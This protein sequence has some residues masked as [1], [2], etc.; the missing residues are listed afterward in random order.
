MNVYLVFLEEDYV[1]RH[2][3]AAFDS[4]AKAEDYVAKNQP[5]YGHDKL[6]IEIHPV[7]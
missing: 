5:R 2:F 6:V 7:Q 3:M 4:E 1:A